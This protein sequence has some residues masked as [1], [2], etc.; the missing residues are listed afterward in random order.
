[1]ILPKTRKTP[2]LQKALHQVRTNHHTKKITPYHLTA[3]KKSPLI[4]L[5]TLRQ[6][7]P[8]MTAKQQMSTNQHRQNQQMMT[9]QYHLTKNVQTTFT[10]NKLRNKMNNFYRHSRYIFTVHAD[11]SCFSTFRTHKIRWNFL[12][13]LKLL[14][15]KQQFY[16]YLTSVKAKPLFNI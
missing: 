3:P 1:M 15:A 8:S 11:I 2:T 14:I 6:R 4:L 5:P 10:K 13:L 12:F 16:N 9:K 7:K